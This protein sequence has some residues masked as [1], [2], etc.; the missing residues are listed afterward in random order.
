MA[1]Q[2]VRRCR[3]WDADLVRTMWC[4]ALEKAAWA[5]YTKRIAPMLFRQVC[6]AVSHVHRNLIVHRDLKPSN[7]FVS[8]EGGVKLLDFG[9]AKLLGDTDRLGTLTGAG[10]S[11]F[12]IAFAA[13]EQVER[14]PITT[15]TDVYALGALLYLL[16]TGHTCMDVA[17]SSVADAILAVR[18][19]V[20]TAPSERALTAVDAQRRGVA[21][22]MR[23]SRTLQGELDAII[24]KAMRREPARRYASVD[25]MADD[26]HR[27]LRGDRVQAK[28][29]TVTYRLRTFVRRHRAA[30]VGI[31][32]TAVAMVAGS[33]MTLYQANLTRV[34]ASRAERAS[35]FLMHMVGEPD[36][37]FGDPFSRIGPNGRIAE[38]IDSSL[39]R[40]PIL[41]RD[42]PRIRARLYTAL[43][44][45]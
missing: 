32:V 41:F 12:T 38:L 1:Y 29:D 34:E 42:D 14:A 25:A 7:V 43:A 19:G 31:G 23:L 45:A 9:V 13:P 20:V 36:A 21:S 40:V 44:R 26:V 39:A 3:W 6:G 24:M 17:H 30:A 35:L 4:V 2:A 16:L 22:T 28:T 33:A 18:E 10:V 5:R 27:F 37:H 11:P 8:A 15:A